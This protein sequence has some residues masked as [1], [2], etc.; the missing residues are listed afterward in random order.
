[1]TGRGR[2]TST[3][4]DQRSQIAILGWSLLWVASFLA[5]DVAI[6]RAWIDTD[7]GF[8]AATFVVGAIGVGWLIAYLRFLHHADELVQKVQLEAMAV[9]VGVGFV[10]GFALLLLEAGDLVEARLPFLLEVMAVAYAIA[11][12]VGRRRYS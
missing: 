11:L 5:I 10:A 9:A 6:E 4:E 8:I 2:W 12:V 7:A 3:D 1:M